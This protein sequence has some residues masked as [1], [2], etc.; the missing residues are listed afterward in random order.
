[1]NINEIIV[2]QGI[3]YGYPCVLFRHQNGYAWTYR[4]ET[5]DIG[6]ITKEQA[7]KQF[8]SNFALDIR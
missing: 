6:N 2:Q 8:E 4:G 5:R 1:M 7:I 3:M